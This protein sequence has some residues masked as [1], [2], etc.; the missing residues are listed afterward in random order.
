MDLR[1]SSHLLPL[2]LLY[3]CCHAVVGGVGGGFGSVV[4][5]VVG[6]VSVASVGRLKLR[7]QWGA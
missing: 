1:D 4:G 5:G 6:G 2:V 7:R 3:C